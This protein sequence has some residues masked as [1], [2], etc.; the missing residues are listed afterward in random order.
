MKFNAYREP[1]PYQSRVV[2]R[3]LLLPEKK[4]LRHS[5]YWQTRWMEEAR[6]VQVFDPQ[7]DAWIDQWWA[8]EIQDEVEIK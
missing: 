8:D 2:T 5:K 6:I 1:E 3:F 7:L 4:R